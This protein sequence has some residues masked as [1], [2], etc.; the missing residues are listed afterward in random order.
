MSGVVWSVLKE[1][2]MLGGG[3]EVRHRVR[4]REAN[5]ESTSEALENVHGKNPISD[6]K[7]NSESEQMRTNQNKGM[8]ELYE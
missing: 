6:A 1:D 4:E 7:S 2:V 3:A 5:S 8:D